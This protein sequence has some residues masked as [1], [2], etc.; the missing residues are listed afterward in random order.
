MESCALLNN[1]FCQTFRVLE[2]LRHGAALMLMT[3]L[4]N[5]DGKNNCIDNKLQ[6]NLK[7]M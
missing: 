7:I 6:P 4:N 5:N 2:L 1:D 3:K